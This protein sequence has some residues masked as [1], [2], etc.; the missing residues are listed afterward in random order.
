MMP[1]PIFL[2]R[3]MSFVLRLNPDE[4]V[5]REK[6]LGVNALSGF[7]VLNYDFTLGF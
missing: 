5:H 4:T 3:L 6:P 1:S 7:F 2:Q